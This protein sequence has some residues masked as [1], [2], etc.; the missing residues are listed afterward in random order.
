MALEG[1]FGR[2]FA[3]PL[4]ENADGG[5]GGGSGDGNGNGTGATG[6]GNKDGADGANGQGSGK[7]GC[8][9]SP[10]PTKMRNGKKQRAGLTSDLQKERKARQEYEKKVAKYEADLETERKRVQALT[11]VS[12]KAPAE[13]EEEA[14]RNRF[15]QLYPELAGLTKEDI[16]AIRELKAKA[17]EIDE[18]NRHH[19]ATHARSMVSGV[20]T[21][22]EKELGG[23]LTDRQRSQVERLYAMQAEQDQ[24]F[25]DRHT[26]GDKTLIEEFAKESSKT[27]LNRRGVV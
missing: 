2:L 20:Y 1:V 4:F 10:H 6:T 21:T 23:K 17:G 15:K 14:I 9:G 7:G 5:S 18:T 19:W 26:N 13:E 24:E 25:L 8:F 22:I 27:G 11:G 3:V 16:Q 12:P